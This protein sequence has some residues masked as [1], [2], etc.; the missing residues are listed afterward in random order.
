MTTAY[1]LRCAD[2]R[3]AVHG[4]DDVLKPLIDACRP[5]FTA[6]EFLPSSAPARPWA[7]HLDDT[8]CG[9]PVP[10]RAGIP[11][12]LDAEHRTLV[13]APPRP[14]TSNRP[15]IR[16]LRALMRRQLAAAGETFVPAAVVSVDG[17]G[18]A[19]AGPTHAGKTTTALALLDRHPA[20]TQ[21][22]ANDD[23]SL[24]RRP[25]PGVVARGYPRAVEIRHATFPHLGPA[26]DALTAVAQPEGP[27]DAVCLHPQDVAHALGTSTAADV[28]LGALVLLAHAPRD[29]VPGPALARLSPTE[30]TAALTPL[31]GDA[32]PY[33]TWL[34]LHLPT[35]R[36]RRAPV[37]RLARTVPVWR[38][39]QTLHTLYHSADLLTELAAAPGGIR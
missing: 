36:P 21:L 18:L 14:A 24:R 30:A 8:A 10:S 33:E 13:V 28:P 38:L 19:L 16:L 17:R 7:V 3:V 20:R 26:A 23:S 22:V 11:V 4:S 34:D 15:H 6:T 9:K 32:D 1:L 12:R 5:Y 31:V 37:A 35:P 29:D 2:A 39:T 25:G 27:D